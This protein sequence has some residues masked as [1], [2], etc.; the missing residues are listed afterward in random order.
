MGPTL[1]PATVTDLDR[2]S[3]AK[4]RPGASTRPA[5]PRVDRLFVEAKNQIASIGGSDLGPVAGG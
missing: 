5:P 2:T 3:L 1:G 4:A